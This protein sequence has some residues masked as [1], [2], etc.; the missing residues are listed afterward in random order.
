[1][2]P[3]IVFSAVCAVFVIGTAAIW[4]FALDAALAEKL[5]GKA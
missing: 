1:M 3:F 2:K 5:L 4:Y